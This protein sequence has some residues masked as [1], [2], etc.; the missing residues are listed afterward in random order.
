MRGGV[1]VR[2]AAESCA[3]RSSC[4]VTL[5]SVILSGLGGNGLVMFGDKLQNQVCQAFMN[6]DPLVEVIN[7]KPHRR[8]PSQGSPKKFEARAPQQ[9]RGACSE[10]FPRHNRPWANGR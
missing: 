4:V 3:C 7:A 9:C 5:E 8:G 6:L 1:E 2:L 10:S